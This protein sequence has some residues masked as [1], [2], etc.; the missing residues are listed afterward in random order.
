MQV[1]LTKGKILEPTL[2]PRVKVCCIGS[3]S[4]A[5]MA[6]RHGADAL[7][8]VAKMPSGPGVISDSLITEIA[9][10]TPPS[11]GSFLLTS[12]TDA[13]AIIELQQRCGVNTVQIVDRLERGSYRDLRLALPG[14]ALV[15]VIHVTG[16]ESIDEAC[17]V[18]ESGVDA[19]L[20]DSGDQRLPVKLLGGTG[21]THDWSISRSIRELVEV[22]LFLAGGLSSENVAR[23]IDEV[24]PFGLDVCSGLRSHGKLDESKLTLF[25]SKVRNA[26]QSA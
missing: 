11:I 14:V 13:D 1:E 19:L 7:G 20:L 26:S 12:E 8:L 18:A 10:I 22:P 23:A 24:Q 21:R 3:M 4:E 9:S 2:H 25:M 15:Q 6:L 16:H 17:R 5:R